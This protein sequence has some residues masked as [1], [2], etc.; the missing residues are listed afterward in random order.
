MKSIFVQLIVFYIVNVSRLRFVFNSPSGSMPIETDIKSGSYSNSKYSTANGNVNAQTAESTRTKVIN[1]NN[2]KIESEE[3]T[4]FSSSQSLS[5]DGTAI[6]PTNGQIQNG[7]FESGNFT[8][9]SV[10]KADKKTKNV[11][12]QYKR[13]RIRNGKAS[14]TK[15]AQYSRKQIELAN[16]QYQTLGMHLQ[17]SFAA[18][19]SLGAGSLM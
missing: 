12:S 10:K 2:F 6:S 4:F 17:G 16:G 15:Y 18:P 13:T 5:N 9:S 11:K 7:R 8:E 14:R 3:K 1:G 19:P